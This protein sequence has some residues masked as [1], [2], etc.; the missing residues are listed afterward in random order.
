MNTVQNASVFQK[1]IENFF[2][3]LHSPMAKENNYECNE[4][5]K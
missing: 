5:L 2:T 3:E 4:A 1:C